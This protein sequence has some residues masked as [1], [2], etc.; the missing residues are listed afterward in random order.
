M[1]RAQEIIVVYKNGDG[2]HL[3]SSN[4]RKVETRSYMDWADGK[5]YVSIGQSFDTK[6]LVYDVF[7]IEKILDHEKS[8]TPESLYRKY[9]LKKNDKPF[10]V[11]TLISLAYGVFT[12]QYQEIFKRGL[13]ECI[14]F[15]AEIQGTIARI[16]SR[17]FHLNAV[18]FKDE[19][20]WCNAII[21]K[22]KNVTTS[23]KLIIDYCKKKGYKILSGSS[24]Y[25]RKPNKY[26]FTNIDDPIV[27]DYLE[28]SK[29]ISHLQFLKQFDSTSRRDYWAA[30][31]V[32]VNHLCYGAI[33]GRIYTKEP[34]LQALALKYYGEDCVAFDY[35][36]QEIMIYLHTFRPYVLDDYINSGATDFYSW[37][38]WYVNKSFD[39]S[40]EDIRI[41]Y[42]KKRKMMKDMLLQMM[43]GGTINGV[44]ASI[45]VEGS[46]LKS[47]F[48]KVYS[49]MG[50]KENREKIFRYIKNTGRFLCYDGL[51]KKEVE[52]E[53]SREYK[54]WSKNIQYSKGVVDKNYK[55]FSGDVYFKGM[56]Y[57]IS[58][59]G[60]L[61][62]KVAAKKIINA[63]FEIICLRHDEVV[64][65]NHDKIGDVGR[66]MK[67]AYYEITGYDIGV[68][69]KNHK[70]NV[71][72]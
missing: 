25:L 70:V 65:V 29:A 18:L 60:S 14:S 17:L 2:W 67:D 40:P 69:R 35:N 57:L 24:F 72:S 34:N 66:L 15:E 43:N 23:R 56:N 47:F 55:R 46:R 68:S 26:K 49:L 3:Y 16:N 71:K 27:K 22:H 13:L 8:I 36:A 45:G 53:I 37:L 62:L 21:E 20:D 31:H 4:R 48:N 54:R 63:G 32:S 6:R 5:I 30:D 50:F 12:R 38:Y 28:K 51:F 9:Y 1:K 33:N 7:T 19:L 10:K 61:I 58:S 59:T 64:I 11:K 44:G 41:K 52:N 42:P 39:G